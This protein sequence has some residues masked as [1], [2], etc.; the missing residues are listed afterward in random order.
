[1]ATDDI[2]IQIY[3]QYYKLMYQVS[4]SILQNF[5]DTEDVLQEAFIRINKNIS[6]IS[7]PFCP[8][9]KN[10][11]VIITKRIALNMLRKKKGI[12]AEELLATLEDVR[13]DASTESANETKTVQELVKMA[14]RDLPDRYRDCLFLSLIDEY[15]PKEIACILEMKEHVIYKRLER[16]KK[17]LQNRLIDLG[18]AYED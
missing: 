18:V 7:D 6:K 14:I 11:V 15:T 5:E 4:Y 12:Q 13:V 10:F 3:E 16:G 2:F 9:T 8:K 17:M 1:M